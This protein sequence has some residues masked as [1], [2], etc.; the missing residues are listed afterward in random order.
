MFC[1]NVK[2]YFRRNAETQQGASSMNQTSPSPPGYATVEKLPTIPKPL[3]GKIALVTGSSRGIG[4]GIA[5]ELGARGA[6]VAVNY[7]KSKETAE[8]VVNQIRSLGGRAMA[9]QADVSKVSEIERLFNETKLYFGK[10]DITIS[11]SGMESFDRTEDITED[12]FDHVFSL[13]FKAQFFVGQNFYKYGEPGG[14][15]ILTSSIAA[16]LIGVGDH[17]LYSSSKSAINGVTKSFAKDF[18]KKNMRV[19]AIAPGGVKSGPY[20]CQPVRALASP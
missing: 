10:I 1:T 9:F 20:P 6:A 7:L 18:G 5:L 15:L 17:A 4:A 11:N 12:R 8:T 13:N 14:C 2:K 3:A 16:G 19:N